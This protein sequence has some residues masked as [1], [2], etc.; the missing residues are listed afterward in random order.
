MMNF[1]LQR[2][3]AEVLSSKAPEAKRMLK[4]AQ[5]LLWNGSGHTCSQAI[6]FRRIRLIWFGLFGI[7]TLESKLWMIILISKG[8]AA[9]A[10]AKKR[11]LKS[12][13]STV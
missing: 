6:S 3:L 10:V 8:V 11:T 12:V 7:Q 2:H 9:K 1:L 5:S 4:P 13:K